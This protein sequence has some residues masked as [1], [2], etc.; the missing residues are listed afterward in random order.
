[1]G[2]VTIKGEMRVHNQSKQFKIGIFPAIEAFNW[3]YKIFI[4]R[5]GITII[6]IQKDI[7]EIKVNAFLAVTKNHHFSL[8]RMKH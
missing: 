3:L 7:A 5:Q 2:K 8:F 4:F 6:I 1:M